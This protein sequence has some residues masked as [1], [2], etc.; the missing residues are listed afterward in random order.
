MWTRR[1]FLS[2]AASA[3][4]AGALQGCA[5]GMIKPPS[6]AS[7]FGSNNP[8]KVIDVHCHIFNASDLQV[9]DFLSKVVASELNSEALSI[10]GQFVQDIGWSF[11][12]SAAEEL[13]WLGRRRTNPD[14]VLRALAPTARFGKLPATTAQLPDITGGDSQSRFE[15]FYQTFQKQRPEQFKN[16]TR[17]YAE[18]AQVFQTR[19]AATAGAI[20]GL[21]ALE[22]TSVQRSLESPRNL[23]T[24][25]EYESMGE[26]PPILSFVKAFFRY[27][28]ENAWLALQTYGCDSTLGVDLIT[29]AMVDFDLWLG[30]P[31]KDQGRTKSHLEDQL[32]LASEIARATAGR[33]HQFTPFNPR[34]AACDS[35]YFDLCTQ[36][37][38]SYGCIGFKLYPP[39]G[40]SPWN[41]RE[42][43]G[44]GELACP[45]GTVSGADLD[46]A[47]ENFYEFCASR[48]LPI[49]AH[50]SPS[51]GPSQTAKLLGSPDHWALAFKQF[52]QY[53]DDSGS[54]IRFSLGH[55]GGDHDV[56][57]QPGGNWTPEFAAQLEAHP[58]IFAD[59][60]YYARILQGPS[61]QA[62]VS[63]VLEQYLKRSPY[64]DRVMYGSDWIM[65]GIEPN[66]QNYLTEM[67]KFLSG[68]MNLSIETQDKILGLN[69]RKF[70]GLEINDPNRRRLEEFHKGFGNKWVF[71]SST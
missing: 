53:F 3:G 39:M 22:P 17:S 20:R 8:L 59:L 36:A 35:T 28:T 13:A 42:I 7:H 5:P 44:G 14:L 65:L 30:S 34:R 6:C 21:S 15:A 4:I 67:S 64:S 62:M 40:F 10:I 25:I 32:K 50:T 57:T 12:P 29:P 24:M 31:S 61:G 16:F 2:S 37:I 49:M 68:P 56:S 45:K 52:P 38:D 63:A 58:Y 46:K 9:G 48:S 41:N 26:M 1:K 54:K 51:N 66:Y 33:V 55:F 27:R 71:A 69:A 18:Q 23:E 47:L 43:L 60:A 19:R 11:A 70:L